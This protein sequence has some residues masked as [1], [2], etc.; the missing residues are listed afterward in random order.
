[1]GYKVNIS[2]IEKELLQKINFEENG[3]KGAVFQRHTRSNPF[4]IY[5]LEHARRPQAAA[6]QLLMYDV[7]FENSRELRGEAVH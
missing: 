7:R 5:D 6:R 3:I 1:M 4:T 2:D